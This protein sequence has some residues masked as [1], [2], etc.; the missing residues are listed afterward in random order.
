MR[1]K[2]QI[3]N[4]LLKSMTLGENRKGLTMR[5]F[6]VIERTFNNWVDASSENEAIKIALDKFENDCQTD[7]WIES[8]EEDE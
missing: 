8:E 5:Y 6:I 7:I 4:I 1:K 3:V 2:F